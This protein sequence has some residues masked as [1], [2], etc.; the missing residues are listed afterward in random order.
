ME[1]IREYGKIS[2]YYPKFVSLLTQTVGVIDI[3]QTAAVE[4]K[5]LEEEIHILFEPELK[6]MLEFFET[7]VRTLLFLRVMLETNLSR[8]AARLIS[9]SAAEERADEMIRD[10]KS[11]LRKAKTS[12]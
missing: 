10:K 6:M 7:Q 11:Q 8:T 4:E 3:T 9:M 1:S 12:F 5:D 2:V